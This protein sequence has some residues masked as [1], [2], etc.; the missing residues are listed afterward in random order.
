[1]QAL[2]EHSVQSYRP[3]PYE[4]HSRRVRTSSRA[5]PYPQSRVSKFTSLPSVSFVPDSS[6]PSGSS[7]SLSSDLMFATVN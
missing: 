6:F 3:L 7:S 1:M 5:S 4:L 2:L